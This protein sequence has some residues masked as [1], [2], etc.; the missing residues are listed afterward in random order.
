M[1]ET[2]VQETFRIGF[3]SV[4]GALATFVLLLAGGYYLIA[5]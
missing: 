1:F 5:G 3:L 4:A 2:S